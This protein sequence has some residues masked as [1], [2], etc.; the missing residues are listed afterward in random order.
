[1]TTF[2]GPFHITVED[3]KTHLPQQTAQQLR[4]IT[5]LKRGSLAV[6]LYAPQGE[7]LQGP[8]T[9]DELYIVVSGSGEFINGGVRHRFGPGDVLFVPA[10]RE[11]RF[12]DFSR[13]FQTW[14]IFYGP[15]GGEQ[16]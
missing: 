16:A 4:F 3:A 7:D 8:H 15:E 5:M 2:S 6:E 9:Q 12:V 1:M 11:H 13:D 14:V 10:G